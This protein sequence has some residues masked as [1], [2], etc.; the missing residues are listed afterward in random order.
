MCI[1]HLSLVTPCRISLLHDEVVKLNILP[2][3]KFSRDHSMEFNT[4]LTNITSDINA[5]FNVSTD[6][7]SPNRLPFSGFDHGSAQLSF[8]SV[9]TTSFT[10]VTKDARSF[11]KD[12]FDAINFN[13]LLSLNRWSNIRVLSDQKL[14][15]WPAT[16]SLFDFHINNKKSSTNFKHSNRIVF[17]SKMLM[18]EL[19]LLDKLVRRRP[20]L[21]K[22]DWKC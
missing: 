20:D 11:M 10:T 5:C 1:R 16:W 22:S 17:N 4:T 6:Q 8:T 18:D 2:R 19:P 21:Y 3:K 7:S 13:D 15:D 14:I 9:N 12:V